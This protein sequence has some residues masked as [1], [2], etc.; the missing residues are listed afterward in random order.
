MSLT[1]NLGLLMRA[2]YGQGTPK[3]AADAL[4]A[5]VFVVQTDAALTFALIAVVNGEFA[6]LVIIIADPTPD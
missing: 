3:E 2:L 5:F 4:N 1:F 6:A